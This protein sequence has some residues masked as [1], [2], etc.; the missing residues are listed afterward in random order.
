MRFRI[1]G[2]TLGW[3]WVALEL[4]FYVMYR[5]MLRSEN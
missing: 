3:G 2:T 1:A 4:P 5:R